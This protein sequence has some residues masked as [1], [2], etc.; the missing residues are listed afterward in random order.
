MDQQILDYLR[1]HPGST[2]SELR[3]AFGLNKRFDPYN[4]LKNPVH[5]AL[6]RLRDAGLIDVRKTL[7]GFGDP[8]FYRKGE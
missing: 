6:V 1:D 3:V 5:Q 4:P 8:S 2:A 7:S